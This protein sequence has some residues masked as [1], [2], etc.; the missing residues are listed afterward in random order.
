MDL[1]DLQAKLITAHAELLGGA[2]RVRGLG[3][4]AQMN[5]RQFA[6]AE[7]GL[8]HVRQDLDRRKLDDD[9]RRR[10]YVH[11]CLLRHA[12]YSFTTAG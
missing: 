8:G 6:A 3:E 12:G 11:G 9:V 1:R 10:A 2:L 7:A 4:L 5:Q